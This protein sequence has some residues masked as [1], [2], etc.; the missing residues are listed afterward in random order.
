MIALTALAAVDAKAGV[1]AS[2][3]KEATGVMGETGG[4]SGE[5]GA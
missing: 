1:F 4:R 2:W 5:F 3:A